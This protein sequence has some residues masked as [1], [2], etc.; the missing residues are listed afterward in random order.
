VR[1]DHGGSMFAAGRTN[2]CKGVTQ[3]RVRLHRAGRRRALADL[4]AP[5]VARV[6]EVHLPFDRPRGCRH[7]VFS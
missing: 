4:L 3:W 5:A 7:A 2:G 6:P 1:F